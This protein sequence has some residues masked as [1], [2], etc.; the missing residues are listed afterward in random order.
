MKVLRA[1]LYTI[2]RERADME[3]MEHRRSQVCMPPPVPLYMSLPTKLSFRSPSIS[4][5]FFF[6]FFVCVSLSSPLR[7]RPT[8]A[9]VQTGSARTTSRRT[10]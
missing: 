8:L 10:V 9:S 5:S 2:E 1:R 3:R 4:L 6:L 7:S